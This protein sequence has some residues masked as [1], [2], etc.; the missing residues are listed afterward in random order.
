MAVNN[1]GSRKIVIENIE[2]RWSVTGNDGFIS[3]TIWNSE[4]NSKVTGMFDYHTEMQRQE[5]GSYTIS[6]GQ[7]IITNRVIR[8]IIEHV[9]PKELLKINNY[10]DLGKLE[11]IYDVN[12]ALRAD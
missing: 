4:S 11:E 7:I 2:Y 10:I 8:N 6:K 3:V 12:E 9:T 5:N 1:K